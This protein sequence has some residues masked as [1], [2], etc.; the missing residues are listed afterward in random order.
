MASTKGSCRLVRAV[1]A[2]LPLSWPED[3]WTGL[4]P[5]SSVGNGSESGGQA[6]G[7]RS[8]DALEWVAGAGAALRCGR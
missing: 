6:W 4:P 5:N 3:V 1:G 7:P 8:P 2:V